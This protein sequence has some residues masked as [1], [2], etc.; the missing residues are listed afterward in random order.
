MYRTGQNEH[1]IITSLEGIE[2]GDAAGPALFACGLKA[3]LDELRTEV[4]RLIAARLRDNQN[5]EA[6]RV[7]AGG[8]RSVAG[9]TDDAA[10]DCAEFLPI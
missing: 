8:N 6:N 1:A 7:G 2:Q 5:S 3:P 4:R 10:E 9:R